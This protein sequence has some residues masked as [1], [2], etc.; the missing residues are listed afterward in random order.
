MLDFFR[1]I[2]RLYAEIDLKLFSDNNTMKI[3]FFVSNFEKSNDKENLFKMTTRL[4]SNLTKLH[5]RIKTAYYLNVT[6]SF[7]KRVSNS[8]RVIKNSSTI[9]I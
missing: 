3:L 4:Q 7:K 8:E 5:V 1:H 2:L 9:K 6:F